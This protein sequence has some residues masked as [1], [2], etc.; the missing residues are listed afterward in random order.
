MKKTALLSVIVMVLSLALTSCSMFEPRTP[1]KLWEKIE[2]KMD[3]LDSYSA[4]LS[5]TIE[6]EVAGVKITG[7]ETGESIVILRG[8]GIEYAY[9]S[10]TSEMTAAGETTTSDKL[11]VYDEGKMY[12][13]NVNDKDHSRIYSDISAS[14]FKDYLFDN[15]SFEFSPEG[16]ATTSITKN[17]DSTWKLSCSDYDEEH[18]DEMI[19][20]IGLDT[21]LGIRIEDIS[22]YAIADDKYRA[23]EIGVDIYAGT[24]DK[25]ILSMVIEYSDF[26]EAEKKSF[27]KENFTE[28]DEARIAGWINTGMNELLGQQTGSFTLD[29]THY[30]SSSPIPAYSETDEITFADNNGVYE[31]EIE[32]TISGAVYV[33]EYKGGKQTIKSNYQVQTNTQTDQEAKLYITSLLNSSGF[34]P[35]YVADVKLLEDGKYRIDCKVADVSA[36]KQIA[37]ALGSGYTGYELYLIAEMDGDDLVSLES[38][39]TVK[40]ATGNYKINS[41]TTLAT[42]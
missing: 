9:E 40:S 27:A 17:D 22:F 11:I 1:E 28:V 41:V 38:Y 3:K 25:P 10:V 19:G 24:S 39:L 29:V 12:V 37:S 2:K 14:D 5:A 20:K 42:D 8:D 34:A 23:T 35:Q 21:S 4:K 15:T 30:L 18:I 6:L 31:Y 13:A 33:I 36:Y 16:A 7:E 32:A 26:N